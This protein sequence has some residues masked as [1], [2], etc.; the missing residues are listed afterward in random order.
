MA[1][2]QPRRRRVRPPQG[3]SGARARAWTRQTRR[4]SPT[5][6]QRQRQWRQHAPSV[7]AAAWKQTS[8][9]RAQ[10]PSATGWRRAGRSCHRPP[11]ERGAWAPQNGPPPSG[12]TP[13]NVLRHG[14]GCCRLPRPPCG[15]GQT[16]QRQGG[17][18]IRAQGRQLSLPRRQQVGARVW[19]A[20][21]P[22][23]WRRHRRHWQHL[24]DRVVRAGGGDGGFRKRGHGAGRRGFARM[25]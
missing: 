20:R 6:R 12:S 14:G 23:K 4:R 25:S 18:A 2:P 10:G 8:R 15:R 3:P 19:A 22:T 11:P 5:R 9:T 13:W 24:K 1:P 7:A 17:P 16:G 21:P